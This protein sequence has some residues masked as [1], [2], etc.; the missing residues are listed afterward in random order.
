M[1]DQVRIEFK[2]LVDALNPLKGLKVLGVLEGPPTRSFPLREL[3]EELSRRGIVEVEG[4]RDISISGLKIKDLGWIIFHCKS[5]DIP[6]DFAVALGGDDA[7]D[8]LRKSAETLSRKTKITFTY[9]LSAILH[10]IQ[11]IYIDKGEDIYI[12]DVEE[13]AD[14]TADWLPEFFQIIN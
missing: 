1:S 6:D 2:E 12:I 5:G 3:V 11:G 7:W 9:A 13:V 8:R 4:Y 14:E 10:G